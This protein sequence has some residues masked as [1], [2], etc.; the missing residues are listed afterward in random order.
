MS[1]DFEAYLNLTPNAA[2]PTIKLDRS[3]FKTKKGGGTQFSWQIGATN[4]S[5]LTE[6]E[7]K[8]TIF[9]PNDYKIESCDLDLYCAALFGSPLY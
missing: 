2:A 5:S 8:E 6:V 1:V 4:E 9:N 7:T 3:K